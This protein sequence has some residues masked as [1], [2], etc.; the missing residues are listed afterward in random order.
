MSGFCTS[1]PIKA[2]RILHCVVFVRVPDDSAGFEAYFDVKALNP[3][4]YM[5]FPPA[6]GARAGT[7]ARGPADGSLAATRHKHPTAPRLLLY[8]PP[9]RT[10]EFEFTVYPPNEFYPIIV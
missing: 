4:P 8:C 3:S 2:L 6:V 9:S 1:M 5:G 10:K 7:I